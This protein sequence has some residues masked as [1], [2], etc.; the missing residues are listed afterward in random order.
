MEEQ[1]NLVSPPPPPTMNIIKRDRLAKTY[2]QVTLGPAKVWD[3]DMKQ[4]PFIITI[5]DSSRE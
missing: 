4:I 2:G 3:Q 1:D 5:N